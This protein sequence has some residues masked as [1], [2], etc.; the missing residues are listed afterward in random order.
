MLPTTTTTRAM[1]TTQCVNPVIAATRNVFEMMLEC[2]PRRT[3]LWLKEAETPGHAVSAVIGITGEASGTIVVSF[4]E[5]V[6]IEVLRRMVGTVAETVNRDV[7]DAVGEL[8]NMIA[9]GAKAQLT[10][11]H[12]SISIPNIVTG[13][14]HSVRY[15]SD[16]KPICIQ[17]ESDIGPFMIEVGFNFDT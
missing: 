16:I 2:T 6:A 1:T 10:Q 12:L 17:F 9:G 8:T 3:G 4:S 13:Q 15:P 14:N 11:L 7:C 5:E